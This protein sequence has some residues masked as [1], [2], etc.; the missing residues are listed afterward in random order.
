[1]LKKYAD[2]AQKLKDAEDDR[3]KKQATI[4]IMQRNN[5]AVEPLEQSYPY[6]E[7]Y[8]NAIVDVWGYIKAR[9]RK[10]EDVEKVLDKVM[11]KEY[12]ISKD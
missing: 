2:L 8:K 6:K 5:Q 9:E 4:D 12:T 1:M 10:N 3:D 11:N 7:G